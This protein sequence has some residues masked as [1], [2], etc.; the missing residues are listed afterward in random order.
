MLGKVIKPDPGV[1]RLSAYPTQKG[2]LTFTGQPQ[3]VQ[4]DN[5]DSRFVILSG[6]ITATN[7]GEYAATATPAPGYVWP[8]GT[9]DAIV[10]K[11]TIGRKKLTSVPTQKTALTYTGGSQTVTWSTTEGLTVSGTQ[12]ATNA[13]TYTA[14]ATP[15][16]NHCWSDGSTGAKTLTWTIGRKA[17]SVPTQK[18]ALTYNGKGQTVTWTST[19]GLT[20]SGTQSAT[21]AGTYSPTATPDANHKWSDGTTTAKTLTW[22][23]AKAAGSLSVDKSSVTLNNATPT[24]TIQ[25]TQVGDGALTV[26]SSNPSVV[27][28]TLDGKKL[29]L[30][31]VV[32]GT[33]TI[34]ISAAE[35]MNYLKPQSV[36]VNVTVDKLPD[37]LED[38]TPAQI[39]QA[40]DSGKFAEWFDV[41]GPD[42]ISCI[43]HLLCNAV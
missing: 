42:V 22:T 32:N 37:S 36:M 3:T 31:G 2:T 7:A 16:A 15:D 9:S 12:S 26:T 40:V 43:A 25:I 41:G 5:Y 35:G 4:L 30:G 17:V 39:K 33:A 13:G 34:T 10:I 14:T 24:A 11:W 19:E 28:A 1:Q 20:F 29:N 38:C 6:T 8:N 23:I 27:T 21:N 18:T